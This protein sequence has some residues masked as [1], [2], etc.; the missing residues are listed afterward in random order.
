M[1]WAGEDEG[2]EETP[3]LEGPDGENGKGDAG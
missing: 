3:K 2:D 1:S